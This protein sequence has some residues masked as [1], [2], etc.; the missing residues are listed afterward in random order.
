MAS[1]QRVVEATVVMG[2]S[3]RVRMVA[4]WK[5]DFSLGDEREGFRS[6]IGRAI[7]EGGFVVGG[8]GGRRSLA[9]NQSSS[10]N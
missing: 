9:A 6:R 1:E 8:V 5:G 10:T 3:R 2:L 4:S 7:G